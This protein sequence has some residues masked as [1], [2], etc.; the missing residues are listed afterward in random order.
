MTKDYVNPY[1][2]MLGACM[3]G[4][5]CSGYGCAAGAKATPLSTV[6]PALLKHENFEL[7]T[8][9]NAIGVKLDS[10]KKRAVGVIYVDARG[11]RLEQP[12]ELVILASYT[13]N[14]TRLMLLSG[15]GEPYDPVANRGVIGRNYAYQPGGKVSLF[16]EDRSF[17]QFM[18]GG[19]L[20]TSIDEFNG[21]NFDHAGLGFMGGAYISVQTS[22]AP[23]M[24]SHP[25]PHG[26]PRWGSPWK[27]A[28]AHY[29]DRAFSISSHGSCQ[30]H[31]MCYLD[32][33]P[34]YRDAYGLP[35]LRM[36]FD[37]Q[38]NERKMSAYTTEKAAGIAR[39]IG[40]A[41]M[42][43]SPLK[44]KYSIVPRQATHNTGGAV[45]GADPATSA[46]N[47]YLQSWDVSNVFVVG[48]SAFPQN[49]ANGPSATIGA[50]SCWTADAIKDQYLKRPGPLV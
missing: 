16:F 9:A 31:R 46:V 40:P 10:E 22:G 3:R 8:H 47:K 12:A 6:V 7:R 2:L 21:D 24:R 32:L 43:V 20:S 37:W 4:G 34:T 14:N 45:M 29:Y 19:G 36:T 23:P 33:D 26:T 41:K 15:I 11:R 5:Y 44:G 25:T 27:S 35:L 13:F 30:S 48:G 50:L 38:D 1:R 17:N 28:V 49:S 39:A 18:G 42:G